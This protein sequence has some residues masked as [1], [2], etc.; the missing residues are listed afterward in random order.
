M[1]IGSPRLTRHVVLDGPVNVRDLGGYQGRAGQTLRWGRLYRADDLGRATAEDLAVLAGLGVRTVIDL[2]TDRERAAS[3]APVFR[4]VDVEVHHLP[5]V[6]HDWEASTR[7][8]ARRVGPAGADPDAVALLAQRSLDMMVEGA[9]AIADAL[10][11]LA[12]PG[13]PP[14]VL[15]SALGKDRAGL[16]SAIVLALLGVATTTIAEDY[17]RSASVPT[18]EIRWSRGDDVV[19]GATRWDPEPVALTAPPEAMIRVLEQVNQRCGSM[20]GFARGIGVEFEVIE[21]LHRQL[22]G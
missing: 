5:M 19:G 20:V 2:R 1:A 3:R 16:L 6:R 18:E 11:I 14:A 12:L 15:H 21:A 9:P 10:R 4:G 22:L 17:A 13:A 7:F 8:A